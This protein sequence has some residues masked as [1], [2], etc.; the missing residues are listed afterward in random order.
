VVVWQK[1]FVRAAG[2]C[3]G[4]AVGLL[5]FHGLREASRR[6]P[7]AGKETAEAEKPPASDSSGLASRNSLSPEAEKFTPPAGPWDSSLGA[8]PRFTDVTEAAGISFH[9]CNGLTGN[10]HYPEIMGGGVALFDYDGDGFLDI[11]FV[12]G[13]HLIGEP[14]PEIRNVLYRNNG[15]GTFTDVTDKAGVGDTGFGQGCC[16]ADY[17]ADGDPDLYISNYGVNVL[18]RNNGDGTFTDV[19]KEAGVDDPLWGQSSTFL[20]YDRD[21]RIDLYVQNYLTYSLDIDYEAFIYVGDEKVPDYP[22]PANFKGAPD[23]LYRNNGDGTFTDV[24]EKAGILKPGGKGMGIACF[25]MDDDGYVDIFVTN[26]GMEN[27]L[28]HN[29]GDGTFEEVGLAAGVAFDGVG[30]PESSMGVDVGDFN[31]DGRLDM[32]VPCTKKQIYTLYE[33]LGTYFADASMETGLTQGTSDRTGFNANFLDYDNDGDLD[34][35]FTT[36]GVRANELVPATASYVERYG[37]YDV[38]MANNGKGNFKDVSGWAG[39][40][41]HRRLIGRGSATGDLDNDGDIDLVISNLN[42]PAVV[43]RN[44]TPSGHW[45]TVTLIGK[46]GNR[47]ALGASVRITAGGRT[48]RAV[49]HGGVTYLSQIDR[50]VHFGLGRAKRIEKLEVTWPDGKKVSFENLAPDRFV[51]IEEA[52]GKLY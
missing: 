3:A 16:V 40:H 32:I 29:K 19:A 1:L 2:L 24:T 42:G 17:D 12:N 18:Y 31:S 10:Y 6:P 9:H 41:F 26:D 38:L 46:G 4:F 28:F 34:L 49:V 30:I 27:Y 13:N 14:S 5:L 22:S 43:L 36:G 50:R 39:S 52:T 37:Y 20:D 11:Y 23:H 44:D 8:P 33:N 51:T 48:Q 35:F 21:G 45:I 15:D 7:E 25:D 47:D